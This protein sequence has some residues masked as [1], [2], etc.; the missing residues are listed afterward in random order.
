MSEQMIEVPASELAKL[1]DDSKQLDYLKAMGV[2]NWEGYGYYKD[3]EE[4]N[5]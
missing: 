5:E 2:D 3:E 1:L 4:D